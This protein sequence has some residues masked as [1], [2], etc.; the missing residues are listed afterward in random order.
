MILQLQFCE[1]EQKNLQ[2]LWLLKYSKYLNI[3]NTKTTPSDTHLF[4]FKKTLTRI[5]AKSTAVFLKLN[6]CFY[7]GCFPRGTKFNHLATHKSTFVE[8]V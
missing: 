2:F 4:C 3:A 6:L 7:V 1:A 8:A 5:N